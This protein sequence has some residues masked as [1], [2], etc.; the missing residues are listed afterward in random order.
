MIALL[1]R[2]YDPT[3]G[4]IIIDSQPLQA[5]SPTRY[6]KSI[7]IFQQESFLLPN[8]VHENIAHETEAVNVSDAEIEAVS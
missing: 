3:S 2:F 4:A 8:S 6:L 5:I 7:S 1:E